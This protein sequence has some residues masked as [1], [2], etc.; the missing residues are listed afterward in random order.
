MWA[1]GLENFLNKNWKC[2][3]F[4]HDMVADTMVAGC[5]YGTN[6]RYGCGTN[7]QDAGA[8]PCAYPS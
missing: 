8:G 1:R 2:S 5:G 6:S 7:F 4:S 3:W